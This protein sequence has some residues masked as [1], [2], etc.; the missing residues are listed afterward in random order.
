ML[1]ITSF[2]IFLYQFSL[3]FGIIIKRFSCKL[4]QFNKKAL[5]MLFTEED[6][7]FTK[8]FVPDYG[9]GTTETYESPDKK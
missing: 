2:T 1:I 9:L 6:K 3:L 5:E 7:T 8:I 4:E